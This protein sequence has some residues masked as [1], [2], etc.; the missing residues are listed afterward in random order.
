[1]KGGID[2]NSHPSDGCYILLSLALF[3]WDKEGIR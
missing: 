3:M 2:L 1:L